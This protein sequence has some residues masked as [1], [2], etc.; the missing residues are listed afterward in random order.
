MF[1]AARRA[2]LGYTGDFGSESDA[3]SA[4]DAPRHEG[5]N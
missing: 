5:F 2:K 4:M 3:A 1:A